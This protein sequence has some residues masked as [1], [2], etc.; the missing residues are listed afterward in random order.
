[1]TIRLL[2]LT[3]LALASVGGA[4]PTTTDPAPTDPAGGATW[5]VQP[6]D[7]ADGQSRATF[8]ASLDP[9]ARSDDSVIITNLGTEQ[10]TLTLAS[11]DM[12][13]TP[14]GDATLAGDDVAPV[15]AEWVTLSADE[16][17]LEPGESADVPFTVAPPANAE[18]GDYAV[19]IIASLAVPVT[20]ADGQQ[21]VLDTRVGARLYLRVIGDLRSDLEISDLT[22]ERDAAWWNSLPAS[23]SADFV[24]TNRGTV[25]LDATA[26]VT[27]TGPFGW[28]LG[29]SP[30]LELPQLLPGE[31]VR[32]SEVA[33]G[34][35]VVDDVV[36]PFVLTAHVEVNATE[37]RTGQAFVFTSSASRTDVPWLVIAALGAAL[38]VVV[39][40]LAARRKRRRATSAA[41]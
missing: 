34:P 18:P 30:E 40:R 5:Q 36:A 14:S 16:V 2:A 3:A 15:A 17:V 22:V 23:A 31:S 33:G 9:G 10:L 41:T 27:L 6:A 24:V 35:A 26:V 11:A 21:A 39:A 1:M 4:L 20:D 25:R 13:T 7:D 8:E 38:A 19:A 29:S 28:E 32:L 37:V 12:V